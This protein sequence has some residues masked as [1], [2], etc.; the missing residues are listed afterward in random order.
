MATLFHSL[1]LSL[2]LSHLLFLTQMCALSLSLFLP[3]YQ[4]CAFRLRVFDCRL[5]VGP[6]VQGC[7]RSKEKERGG[8]RMYYFPTQLSQVQSVRQSVAFWSRHQ[9]DD[10]VC[11]PICSRSVV[12]T[13]RLLCFLKFF[14]AKIFAKKT[15]LTSTFVV[16]KR[17]VQKSAFPLEQV[18]SFCNISWRRKWRFWRRR[19]FCRS[20]WRHSM[21]MLSEVWKDS[22]TVTIL[23]GLCSSNVWLTVDHN[24]YLG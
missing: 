17:W 5:I 15:I 21:P 10:D 8:G 19:R 23:T 7:V 14:K 11:R 6:S 16:Q 12:Q 1:S 13:N 2:S 24:T 9:D 4:K 20:T 18:K 22:K 3:L